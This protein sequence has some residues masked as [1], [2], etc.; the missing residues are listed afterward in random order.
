MHAD[1]LSRFE[2]EVQR[3]RRV[4]HPNVCRVHDLHQ[5]RTAR[6]NELTFYTMEFLE[7]ET[8]R[9]YVRR[10]GPLSVTEALSV[11]QEICA[12]VAEIHRHG[13]VHGDLKSSNIVLAKG[14]GSRRHVK[15]IDFGL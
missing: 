3:A 11:S 1:I 14:A 4:T 10:V 7:G 9:D 6:G 8:L 12:G 5:A 15:I 2:A 13:L